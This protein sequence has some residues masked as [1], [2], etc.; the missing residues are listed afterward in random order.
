MAFKRKVVGIAF[1]GIL[2]LKYCRLGSSV[3][4]RFILSLSRRF[5]I[6]KALFLYPCVGC[7]LQSRMLVYLFTFIV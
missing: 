7:N 5:I 4:V 3:W 6:R 1:Q 2:G